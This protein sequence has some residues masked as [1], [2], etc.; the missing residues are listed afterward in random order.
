[1]LEYF[2][3]DYCGDRHDI[4]TI[5]LQ[6][7]DMLCEKCFDESNKEEGSRT[8]HIT[9]ARMLITAVLLYIAW[10]NIHWSVALLL[11]LYAIF[12]E[13]QSVTIKD[14]FKT[15]DAVSEILIKIRRMYKP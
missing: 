13:I 9:A 14:A 11:S 2:V 1:M 7:D 12:F 8:N 6:D 15:L 3:C 4:K 10:G 5:C